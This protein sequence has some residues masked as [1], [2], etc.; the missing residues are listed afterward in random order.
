MTLCRVTGCV[1]ATQKSERL[2]GQRLLV[3]QKLN[4][5]GTLRD[6]P[7]DVALD[8]GLDAGEGDTVLVAKEGAVVAGLLDREG[9]LPT[10]AN[11]IIVA[12]VDAAALP[13]V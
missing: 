13:L 11:V 12:V 4:L 9:E 2:G 7:E 6:G 8:P 3:V 10:P 1:V 5:D